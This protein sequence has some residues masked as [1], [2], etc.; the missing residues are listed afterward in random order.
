MI[1]SGGPQ[2]GLFEAFTPCSL[3]VAHADRAIPP[4]LEVPLSDGACTV[5]PCTGR[6]SGPHP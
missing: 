2:G 3:F 1:P 6:E 4:P 5:H